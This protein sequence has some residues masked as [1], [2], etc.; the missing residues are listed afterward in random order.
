MTMDVN[1]G[2]PLGANQAKGGF[3]LYRSGVKRALDLALV[4]IA[5]PFALALVLSLALLVALDGGNPFYTQLRVGRGGRCFRLLK[6]RTMVEDADEALAAHLAEHADAR[7]EWDAFQKLRHDPRITRLGRILRATS[8]DELPQLW[9]VLLGDMSLVGPRPMLPS[10]RV[11]YEGKAYYHL[12]PGLTGAWQI[13][14]R[15]N[16]TFAERAEYDHEYDQRLSLWNDLLILAATPAVVL[17]A[18]GH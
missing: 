5:A 15:N 7:A 16:S 2:A 11:E 1:F 13:S 14:A 10:Q 9:N 3:E 18:T 6:L 8:L 4:I 12:R 17:R